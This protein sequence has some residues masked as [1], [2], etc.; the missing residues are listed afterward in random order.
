VPASAELKPLPGL[1]TFLDALRACGTRRIAVTNST[2]DNVSLMLDALGLSNA[3]ETVIFGA[4]CARAKP[5][6][7]PYLAGLDFLD[8]CPEKAL[9]FEDS[10]AGVQ[11]GVAAGVRVVAVATT[12]SP[13][14]LL[15]LGAS[16]VVSDYTNILL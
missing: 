5:H 15:R 12:Q 11:S 14:T 13:E 6:P 7:D 2:P 4:D 3:F 10:P 8:L 1:L 9:I 16:D